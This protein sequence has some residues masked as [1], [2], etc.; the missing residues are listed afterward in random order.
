MQP[1]IA[2]WSTF[3]AVQAGSA[4]TLTGLVFVAVSVNV[5]R[6]LSVSG[7][8]SRAAESLLQLLGVFFISGR[9]HSGTIR[10]TAWNGSICDGDAPKWTAQ[11]TDQL[12]VSLHRPSSHVADLPRAQNPDRYAPFLHRRRRN[13]YGSHGALGWLAFGFI[14]SLLPLCWVRAFCWSKSSAGV[15]SMSHGEFLMARAL[16]QIFVERNLEIEQFFPIRIPQ[17]S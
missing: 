14:A 11:I 15:T 6:I 10:E 7:L 8:S 9:P 13:F 17:H 4:A 3:F 1:L 12:P 5:N 16:S 2:E